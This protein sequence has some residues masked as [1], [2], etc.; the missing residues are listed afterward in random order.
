[1]ARLGRALPMSLLMRLAVVRRLVLRDVAAHG[2]R[3]TAAQTA[4]N[5]RDLLGCVVAE[6]MLSTDEEIEPLDT[7]PCPITLAWAAE[8]KLLPL[9]INGAVARG[10]IPQAR[11]VE[12]PGVGHVAMIDDPESVARTILRTTAG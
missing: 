4:E 8:D 12:L 6:D 5:T 9:E 10:R 2:D 7:L 1:M 11:F 3:L